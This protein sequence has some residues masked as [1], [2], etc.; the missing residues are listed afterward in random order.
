MPA[1]SMTEVNKKKTNKQKNE[2]LLGKTITKNFTF[3]FQAVSV[4]KHLFFVLSFTWLINFYRL[5]I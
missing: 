3:L 1:A 5:N 4:E 2:T